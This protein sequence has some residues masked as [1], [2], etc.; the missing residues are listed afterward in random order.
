MT[1]GRC[2][3]NFVLDTPSERCPLSDDAICPRCT[4]I[5]PS[6]HRCDMICQA[7]N[8]RFIKY[9]PLTDGW[10]GFGSMAQVTTTTEEFMP[11]TYRFMYGNVG[12]IEVVLKEMNT[13]GV[14][15]KMQLCGNES[16]IDQTYVRESW[17][18]MHLEKV[19]K[20]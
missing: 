11:Y 8:M 20:E 17:K 19:L 2:G 9:H 7:R 5:D 1:C 3:R 13:L 15:I 12:S 10:G 16:L 18:T 14:V 4:L 6:L